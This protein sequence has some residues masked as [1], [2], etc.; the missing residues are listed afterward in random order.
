MMGEFVMRDLEYTDLAAL[1]SLYAHLHPQDDP[2]PPP[3]QLDQSWRA[4]LADPGQIY[5]GGFVERRLVAACNAAVIPN[6]TRGARPYAVIENVVTDARF[7]RQGLGGRLLR[8]LVQRCWERNCYKVML[9]S[10]R[11]REEIYGFYQS[12]GFDRDAKQAFVISAR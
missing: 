5:L 2:L 11:G 8:Q 6:L 12:L 7:R 10:G 4:I 9:M 3:H 1:L